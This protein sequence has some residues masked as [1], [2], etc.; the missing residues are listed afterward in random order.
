MVCLLSLPLA[1]ALLG[2]FLGGC[3]EKLGIY[4]DI[5]SDVALPLATALLGLF[6]GGYI[7]IL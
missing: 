4:R 1:T 5:M 2:L 6:V 3:I 7:E